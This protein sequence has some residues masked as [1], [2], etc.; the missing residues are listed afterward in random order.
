MWDLC[1][2]VA[3]GPSGVYTMGVGGVGGFPICF[4]YYFGD[5]GWKLCGNDILSNTP[6]LTP[7]P[8]APRHAVRSST[9]LG[10][11]FLSPIE[12]ESKIKTR[13]FYKNNSA[14]VRS[15]RFYKIYTPPKTPKIPKNIKKPPKT[16]S[17]TIK[18]GGVWGGYGGMVPR[19]WFWDTFN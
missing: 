12:N 11:L 9:Y 3:G 18:M 19:T 15:S 8:L 7:G 17:Q 2:R 10:F 1:T 16:R 6:G 4:P 14:L 5:F 13:I